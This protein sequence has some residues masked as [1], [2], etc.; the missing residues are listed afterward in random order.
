MAQILANLAGKRGAEPAL[1]DEFGETNWVD[2]NDRVNRLIHILQSLELEKG[3]RIAVLTGNR[4]E[5]FELMTA[6]SHASLLVVPVNWH[7]VAEEVEYIIK[8]SG[9]EALFADDRFADLAV[10]AVARLDGLKLKAI[11][12]GGSAQGFEDYET[13]LQGSSAE[14]PDNQGMGGV[15]FYTSG[16]TGRPKGVVGSI[17]NELGIDPGVLELLGHGFS[18]LLK[19]PHGGNTLLCGPVYHSA[20][21]AWSVF[22][23]LCGSTIVMRHKFDPAEVLEI[24]DDHKITNVHLVPTQFIRMLKV[25]DDDP[26]RWK[27]FSGES[28]QVVWHGAAPCSPKIKSEMIDWFGPK[29]W[30][31]YGGTEG[32]IVSVISSEEWLER[33]ASVG[34]PLENFTVTIVDDEG[35]PCPTGTAGNIYQQ[36]E[37]GADFEYHNKPEETEKRHMAPGVFTLGDVGYLDEEGYLYLTDRKI[38]MIISGGVNIYPAEIEG[39]LVAHPAVNDAAVFGIPHEEFGEEIKAVIELVDGAAPGDGTTADLE[40]YCKEH[41]AGFKVPKSFDYSNDMP[42]TPTGKLYKRLLREPYWEGHDKRI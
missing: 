25:R 22:P 17:V 33:P 15:M 36:N 31:Y 1:I 2:L 12:G 41:L 13:L 30:E 21:W 42:R 40:A 7:F 38:D 27:D 14:E 19:T 29:I 28:L 8:D 20:Q 4:R 39:V 5:F 32:S 3:A 34:K 26:G 35:N 24:F 6:A 23:L 18:E 10:E 37:T 9:A 16:T 11:W